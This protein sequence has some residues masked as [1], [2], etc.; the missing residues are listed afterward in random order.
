MS[1]PADIVFW[2]DRF[3][4]SIVKEEYINECCFGEDLAYW[5][6]PKVAAKGYL[7]DD[8]F[9]EDWGWGFGAWGE[10]AWFFE[11]RSGEISSVGK[12][13]SEGMGWGLL[14]ELVT[15]LTPGPSP[16]GR[17]E[18]DGAGSAGGNSRFSRRRSSRRRT[19]K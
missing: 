18:A 8:V 12:W 17:G 13:R 7:V 4:L 1:K 11:R 9:Q 15:A 3:N 19:R 2:T 5:L 16:I 6:M 10:G 14:I